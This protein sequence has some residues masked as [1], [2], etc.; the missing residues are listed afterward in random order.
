M[1]VRRGG[2]VGVWVGRGV[3]GGCVGVLYSI[4]CLLRDNWVVSA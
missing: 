2:C 4:Y 1:W 3:G